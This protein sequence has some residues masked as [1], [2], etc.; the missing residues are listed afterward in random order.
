MEVPEG[1]VD[2]GKLKALIAHC[3]EIRA[4]GQGSYTEESWSV[5]TS[6]LK[7]AEDILKK[8]DVTQKEVMMR[9]LL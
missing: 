8:A 3:K 2:T 6:A 5:F 9:I 1:T 4:E 7:K